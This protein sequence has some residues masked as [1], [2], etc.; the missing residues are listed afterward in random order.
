[1][2]AN[3]RWPTSVNYECRRRDEFCELLSALVDGNVSCNTRV[4]MGLQSQRRRW[5]EP[6]LQ[7]PGSS[8]A[9][10]PHAHCSRRSA[11]RLPRLV[12]PQQYFYISKLPLPDSKRK[13]ITWDNGK[14]K[15]RHRWRGTCD[16]NKEQETSGRIAAEADSS[17]R[18]HKAT[19]CGR[20]RARKNS[21]RS[22]GRQQQTTG[23]SSLRGQ[24]SIHRT[25][26][27]PSHYRLLRKSSPWFCCSYPSNF[28]QEA[29][30]R[31]YFGNGRAQIRF[32][33]Y[34]SLQRPRF[35]H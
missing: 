4:L 29:L 16:S 32:H 22:S 9:V 31:S 21:S 8:L 34:L 33:G 26:N 23:K 28:T 27:N 1:M 20:C 13:P 18:K 30:P 14:K 24:R 19:S 2:R 17:K 35:V 25:H 6:I 11:T 5:G 10:P 15:E 3:E 7:G 12:S